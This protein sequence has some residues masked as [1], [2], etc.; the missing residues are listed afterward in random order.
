MVKYLNFPL[1]DEICCLGM[2]SW[3]EQLTMFVWGYPWV[4]PGWVWTF[5]PLGA[6]SETPFWWLVQKGRIASIAD[7]ESLAIWDG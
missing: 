1:D 7:Q 4:F 3:R 2:V 6:V 5:T